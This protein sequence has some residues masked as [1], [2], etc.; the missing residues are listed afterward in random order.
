MLHHSVP[1][2]VAVVLA[3]APVLG[4]PRSQEYKKRVVRIVQSHLLQ[5]LD[6]GS[7]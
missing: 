7:S 6:E 2:F 1:D 3:T 5:D 4:F